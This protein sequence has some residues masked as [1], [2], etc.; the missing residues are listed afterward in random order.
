MAIENKSTNILNKK[1]GYLKEI[2]QWVNAI[3]IALFIALII[4]GFIFELV[5][6]DGQSMEDTLFNGQRLI[7]YKLGYYFAPPKKGDIIILQVADGFA[8]NIPVIGKS[9]FLRKFIPDFKETDYVKRVIGVPGDEIDVKDGRVYING[10]MYKEPYAKGF[11]SPKDMEFPIKIPDNEYF[12][13]GDNRENSMD[14]RDIGLINT[15]KI[16]GKAVLRLWPLDKAGWI[17]N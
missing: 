3:L 8:V 10:E 17:Y 15:D 14:S 11:T 5:L 9:S 7:V 12:V 1:T 2:F 4:R 13:M 16:E 6:V